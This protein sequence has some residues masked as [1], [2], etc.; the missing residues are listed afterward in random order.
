MRNP[1]FPLSAVAAAVLLACAAAAQAQNPTPPAA[2]ETVLQ[3]VTVNASADASQGGLPPP[4]AG[5]Q[6]ARGSRLGMLGNVSTMDA[7]F[8]A[9]AY[10]QQLIQDQ[11]ARSVADV[12][13]NDPTVRVARGFGNYQELYVIRGFPV[14]SDDMAYNGL[15]GIL[16]RQYVATELLERVEVLRGANTF[17]NGAA[18]GNGGIGGSI[19][20]VPKRA[21]REPLSQVTAG[22]ESG[23]QRYL[24]TDLARRFG[25][26][27]ATGIRINAARR[28]GGTAIDDE[29]RKLNLLSVGVDHRGRN[30]RL[31]ADVG[32]QEH[33]LDQSR[34][35]VDLSPGIRVPRAPD[36]SSN[37]GQP[38]IYSDERDV[39]G[40]VR[41]EVDISADITAWA[42]A[43]MRRGK[44]ENSLHTPRVLNDAGDTGGFRFDNAR[45]DTVRTGEA[46]VRAK[47]RTGDVGH[48][49]A[50]SASAFDLKERNA[51]AFGGDIRSNLYDPVDVP[52][53]D[54]PAT[55]DLSDPRVTRKTRLSSIAVS[56]TLSFAQDSV[57]LTLGARHQKLKETGYAAGTGAETGR[58]DKSA[59]T[60]VAGLVYKPM[61]GLSLYANYAEALTR[62]PTPAFDSANPNDVFSPSRSKQ[63]EIGAKYDNGSFGAGVALFDVRQPQGVE[64]AANVFSVSGEQRNR[65]LE[66]TVYGRAMPGLRLLGGLTLLDAEQKD[67]GAAGNDGNDVIGAPKYQANLGA[68]WDIPGVQGL[69]LTGRVL[70][71]GSQYADAANTQKLPAWTRLDAGVRYLTTVGKQMLTLR[72]SVE[73]LTDR[74]YWASAGGYPGAGYLVLG[75]PRTFVISASLDF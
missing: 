16:P 75:N 28:D 33:K 19:N 53:P 24:A 35:S 11:Q 12:L 54:V 68:E 69:T 70:R 14:Q 36:A 56:D 23:G 31:S 72:A 27:Q 39:F 44:E 2:D 49:L 5:G 51:F 22:I 20:L 47:L 40:T 59:V 34:P 17:L 9:T 64:D 38:W 43:G 10:T 21:P 63:K 58:Y 8:S 7:P 25:E 52:P 29:E 57:L 26:D 6:V 48:T 18:P 41:G 60:P 67:T 61:S 30:F 32:Y 62:A 65:G 37:Y 13:L 46:G 74:D 1:E 45:R 55:G 73:N 66:L 50:V 4:A 3:T 42:A 71:T 15:Y